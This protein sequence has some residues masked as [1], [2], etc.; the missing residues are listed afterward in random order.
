MNIEPAREAM[1]RDISLTPAVGAGSSLHATPRRDAI[2]DGIFWILMTGLAWAPF[3]FGSNELVAWGINAVVF[4]AL[5][6]IFEVLVLLGQRRHP[7][8]IRRIA[9]SAVLFSAVVVW[10]IVQNAIW[11][12]PAVHNTLWSLTADAL[13]LPVNGSISINR[14]LTAPALLRLITAASVFWVALQLG[15]DADRAHRIVTGIA[16]ICV[17]Y[18]A[19]GL[20]AFAVTPG[21]VLWYE[22]RYID[23]YVSSTFFN[24]NNFAT[25]AGIGFIVVLGLLLKLYRYQLASIGLTRLRLAAF[26]E[27]T[28]K[29]GAVYISALFVVFVALLLSGSRGGIVS[30]L[31][32]SFVL[33]ALTIG[34]SRRSAVDQRDVIVFVAFVV[35]AIFVGFGDAF[36]GKI[37]RQ[38]FVDE[39]RMAIY[40]LTVRSIL[41]SP[42]LGY[43]YGT[44][45]DVFPMF[46]D[47]SID[48]TGVWTMA[49]N[50]YLEI[51]QG[52]GLFFGFLLLTSVG[53]LAV[54]CLRGATTRRINAT[55]PCIAGSVA[56]LVAVN[57][58]VDFGLQ[59]QAITLTFMALLGIGVAQAESS[60]LNLQD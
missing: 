24:R 40:A 45:A 22:N 32:G 13:A 29:A 56:C 59:I 33:V 7:V 16:A 18:A 37:G 55:I 9:V 36:L 43:G 42:L 4:P 14:D 39:S 21:Y 5:A 17:A 60:Q 10:I 34:R 50:T 2:E 12:P 57:A 38:G 31:F 26:I 15:R 25:Y 49:H 30:A 51:F 8:A 20:I 52:L 47:R 28:G 23:G 11:T 46:R 44:F 6:L 53:L 3:W 41:D 19:Y 27:T 35:A 54:R 1:S 58:L 48:I